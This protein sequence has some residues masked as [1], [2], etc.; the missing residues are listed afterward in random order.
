[1]L[2]CPTSSQ[3]MSDRRAGITRQT[4]VNFSTEMHSPR[5]RINC[6]EWLAFVIRQKLNQS[7]KNLANL[8]ARL[9]HAKLCALSQL[10][11]TTPMWP[12]S[13]C[14]APSLYITS[15]N[16]L[17]GGQKMLGEDEKQVLLLL[18]YHKYMGK[19]WN[20]TD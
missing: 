6:L 1:M 7:V 10:S 11:T 4:N 15:M 18:L 5:L 14:Q 13:L 20:S 16:R 2:S 3:T 19:S 8:R 12:F 9:S 17:K